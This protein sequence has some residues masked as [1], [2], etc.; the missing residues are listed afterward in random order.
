M[1]LHIIEILLFIPVAFSVLYIFIFAIASLLPETKHRK[2]DEKKH[3]FV[4]VFPAYA[5]DKV[6][7]DSVQSF[8]KQDYPTNLFQTIV[9]S[10]H[11]KPETN[12]QLQQYPIT[13]LIA[14][15]SPSSKAKALQLAINSINEEYDFI[16]ILDAD[17][18]V[19]PDFLSQLNTYC[20]ADTIALQAHRQAKNQNTPVALLDAISEE[21]NN[22]IFRK[23]HNQI[24]MSSA[25][26]GSGMCF[27]YAWFCD[28]VMQLSTAGEDKELE[29][30]LL[31][32][33]H[34]IAFLDQLPVL[35]EKVQSGQN[36]G[37]QRK[38]WIAAQLHSLISLGKLIPTALRNKRFNMIDKFIQQTLIPRSMLLCLVTFMTIL[39][40]ICCWTYGI[41]WCIVL[42]ML[43]ASMMLSIPGKFY[44]KKLLYAIMQIPLLVF[45]MVMNLL[46][47]KGA[48]K[49]FIHTQHGE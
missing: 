31:L 48:S 8:L 44:S 18:H 41:K 36:F 14:N 45:K 16:V 20:H 2:Q 1:I 27:S 10:D 6:I 25:L 24:G 7:L 32:E 3:R 35:D 43:Y 13:T 33:G 11:M 37:N 4:V 21:I 29:E 19:N 15:Y 46:H 9:V 22:T 30:A 26:I 17:N 34:H 12:T 49:N 39:V 28:H 47:L 23:A 5:E 40:S 42:S 38:R